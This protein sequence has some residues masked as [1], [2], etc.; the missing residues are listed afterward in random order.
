M[1]ATEPFIQKTFE[2][3]NALCFEGVLPYAQD[4]QDY[5]RGSVRTFAGIR[6]SEVRR[7]HYWSP[8]IRKTNMDMVQNQLSLVWITMVNNT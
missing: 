8:V 3:F 7:P 6:A 4:L 2:R 1:I 5:R